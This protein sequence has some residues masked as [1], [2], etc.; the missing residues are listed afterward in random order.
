MATEN[1]V[2]VKDARFLRGN[3]TADIRINNGT[4]VDIGAGLCHR[5]ETVIKA[6][7]RLMI[8]GLIDIHIHGAGGTDVV[9]AGPHNLANMSRT[10]ARL[11]VTSFLAAA[12]Y[13]PADHR[14]ITDIASRPVLPGAKLLGFYLEGPFINAEKRGGIPGNYIKSPSLALM[15][16]ILHQSKKSLKIM[17]MAPELKGAD[18]L[19]DLLVENRITVSLGHTCADYETA[20]RAFRHGY[21]HITHCFNAMNGLHHRRPGPVGA[22]MECQNITV[23]MICDSAHIHPAMIK[24]LFKTMGPER[25]I[26]ISDG[27]RNLGLPDGTYTYDGREYISKNGIARYPDGTL[28]GTTMSLLQLV[29]NFKRFSGCTLEQAL[30]TVTKQP[31]RVLGIDKQKGAIKEGY[32]ADLVL[33]D[34]D[35]TPFIT[36]VDGEVV[37]SKNA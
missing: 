18:D 20:R 1:K 32:D 2:L 3:K 21:S 28:I 13:N 4:I 6:D 22:A 7:G 11:G 36:L 37:F 10:L 8:P 34:S 33:L 35:F 25:L 24:L 26:C 31:A 29:L 9:A 30:D 27:I 16:S 5:D 23:E 15:R 19:L 12:V 17:T 14:Y